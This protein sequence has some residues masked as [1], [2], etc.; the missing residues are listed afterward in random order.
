MLFMF[1][2]HRLRA[3]MQALTT[4][5][6]TEKLH[7]DIETMTAWASAHS[8]FQQRQASLD[9]RYLNNRFTQGKMKVSAFIEKDHMYL[10]FENIASIHAEILRFQ[11]IWSGGAQPL[12]GFQNDIMNS[13]SCFLIAIDLSDWFGH[14]CEA[15]PSDLG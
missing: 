5:E 8:D 2:P 12:L 1:L 9:V 11:N 14:D 6:T 3:E 7:K 15:H 10:S 13:T 4:K